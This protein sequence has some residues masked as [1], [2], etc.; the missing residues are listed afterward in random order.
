MKLFEMLIAETRR[1]IH[2]AEFKESSKKQA[3]DFTRKRK[4]PFE[5]VVVYIILSLK[6]STPCA[7]RRFCGVLGRKEMP[8]VL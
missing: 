7:L 2:S 8:V 1:V 5:E 6:S 3:C 4:M